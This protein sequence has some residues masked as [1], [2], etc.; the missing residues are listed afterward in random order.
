MHTEDPEL[1]SQI[2]MPVKK[3]AIQLRLMI[4][5]IV[6]LI[7][8]QCFNA[9]LSISHFAK[10]HTDS[11]ASLSRV[12]AQ[13]LQRKLNNDI[14][15]GKPLEQFFG[16]SA[17]MRE[18]QERDSQITN[19]RIA[20]ASGKILY[21][22]DNDSIGHNLPAPLNFLFN[23][24][25]SKGHTDVNAAIGS[26]P[27][28]FNEHYHILLP[29]SDRESRWRGTI[30]ISFPAERVDKEVASIVKR[31]LYVLAI[32]TAIAAILLFVSLALFVRFQTG[33]APPRKRIFLVVLIVVG[34]AQI[35]YSSYNIQQFKTSYAN[36]MQS[37]IS[38]PNIALQ[39]E[40]ERWFAGGIKIE[41]LPGM[42]AWMQEIVR[43]T[44]E[45]ESIRI[46]STD[47]KTLYYASENDSADV[48]LGQ[49]LANPATEVKQISHPDLLDSLTQPFF[50]VLT[51]VTL[52]L[53]NSG[54][55]IGD[56]YIQPS[57][58]TL[59]ERVVEIVADSLTVLIISL[60]FVVE[61]IIFLLILIENKMYQPRTADTH[62]TS[63]YGLIRPA[64]FIYLF[65]VDL[66]VSFLPLHMGN[67]YEPI[68]GLSK[69][70]VMGLPLSVSM[71]FAAIT[72]I[73][74][75]GWM[76]RRG[77]HE[78]FI[79][80]VLLTATGACLAGLAD[81]ALQFISARAIMG[82]GYGATIISSQGFVYSRIHSRLHGRGITNLTAALFA[83]SI[84]GT[85]SGGMLAERL[86]F[87]GVFFVSTFMAVIAALL[88]I[89]FMARTFRKP[90]HNE[91]AANSN[92]E[93]G[94]WFHFVF[95]RNMLSLMML[96]SVP[97][98]L[99]MVGV[100]YY[101]SPIFLAQEGIG[102]AHI[103]R[104]VMLYGLCIVYLAPLIGKFADRI[105]SKRYI[106]FLSGVCSAAGT[107]AF[108]MFD[109]VLAVIV[110]IGMLGIAGSLAT[111]SQSVYALGLRATRRYGQGRAMGTYRSVER[112]G[113]VLGPLVVG[114]MFV[115]TGSLE[116]ALLLLGG[117]FLI[118]SILFLV[119]STSERQQ[120]IHEE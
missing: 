4:G 78:P 9:G 86:G 81:S 6:V 91:Q 68:L 77:W 17:Y 43:A 61:L 84:C 76:D 113:Q 101:A 104:I 39:K 120:S 55:H 58:L 8:A 51:P 67:L 94:R 25:Y 1:T 112:F 13:S 12:N 82:I 93:N 15:L 105:E 47:G 14:S 98:S 31:N 24:D 48:V 19:V 29:I 23:T 103:G 72:M 33:E 2:I 16:I 79:V 92:S 3:S 56:L 119:V 44:P 20:D 80:G 66:S 46:T 75:G 45:L 97:G 30:D 60:L 95:N 54:S 90:T 36:I 37:N 28:L 87:S 62:T 5:V 10:L 65:A 109:G 96:S 22:I 7:L 117:T 89:I 74:A 11:L 102:Q 26:E 69:E 18:L 73:V 106:I 59:Q 118:M 100:L 38:K 88:A 107:S 64:A 40:M 50:D 114:A 52:S 70:L 110:T 83:G 41:R 21:S 116:N 32:T 53:K 115:F 27:I 35:L 57:S 108:Y 63:N 111:A 99:I 85:V 49:K 42:A 34:V 71:L